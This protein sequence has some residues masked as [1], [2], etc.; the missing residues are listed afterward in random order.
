ML[1]QRTKLR[2]MLLSALLELE[3]PQVLPDMILR[4]DVR[5]K[6][7]Y[8]SHRGSSRGDRHPVLNFP[9]SAQEKCRL[10]RETC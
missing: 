5:G 8:R 3:H 6:T 10:V 7:A 1:V 4:I 9:N 2:I